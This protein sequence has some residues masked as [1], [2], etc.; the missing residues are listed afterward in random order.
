M[1]PFNEDDVRLLAE[2][3]LKCECGN[4]DWRK[5]AYVGWGQVVIAA[6]QTCHRTYDYDKQDPHG[7][8]RLSSEG[9]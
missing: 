9:N 4:G 2:G 5:F 1:T 3:D 7:Q 6:C 8:W